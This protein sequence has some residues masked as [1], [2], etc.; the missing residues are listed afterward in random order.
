L[1]RFLRECLEKLRNT[2]SKEDDH[3]LLRRL[4]SSHM[5]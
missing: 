4:I 3:R 5:V 2:L 1:F